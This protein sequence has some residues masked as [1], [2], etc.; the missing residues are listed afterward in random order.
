M[1]KYRTLKKGIDVRDDIFEEL[2]NL[3]L[4]QTPEQPKWKLESQG[5]DLT[6]Y[7]AHIGPSIACVKAELLLK[8][9]PEEV[10]NV[11][12]DWDRLREWD[13]YLK[14]LRIIE[15]YDSARD[16]TLQYLGYHSALPNHKVRYFLVFRCCGRDERLNSFFIGSKT[17]VH[18]VDTLPIDDALKERMKEGISCECLSSGWIVTPIYNQEDNKIYS[19]CTYV[20]QIDLKINPH[21]ETER[22]LKETG[23][24]SI[25]SFH[26]Y[27]I[28]GGM[29]GA[30]LIGLK[31][32]VLINRK[33][34]AKKQHSKLAMKTQKEA[35]STLTSISFKN[36]W[37]S[38]FK[39]NN[40]SFELLSKIV[41]PSSTSSSKS[42]SFSISSDSLSP[43]SSPPQ[44]SSLSKKT[45]KILDILN[46]NNTSEEDNLVNAYQSF[47]SLDSDSTEDQEKYIIAT[48]GFFIC[49]NSAS[50]VFQYLTSDFKSNNNNNSTNSTSPTFHVGKVV[51]DIHFRGAKEIEQVD[52]DISILYCNS[53]PWCVPISPNQEIED[54]PTKHQRANSNTANVDKKETLEAE[55][56]KEIMGMDCSLIRSKTSLPD[57][58]YWI[59]YK[60]IHHSSIPK[61]N[62]YKRLQVLPSI[63]I[64]HPI[65]ANSC[66]VSFCVQVKN[67]FPLCPNL[68]SEFKYRLYTYID[69]IAPIIGA[70]I[71]SSVNTLRDSLSFQENGEQPFN[72][73]N[74][75]DSLFEQLENESEEGWMK[76]VYKIA[77]AIRREQEEVEKLDNQLS[78]IMNPIHVSDFPSSNISIPSTSPTIPQ[79]TLDSSLATFKQD[80]SMLSAPPSISP[81]TL[82]PRTHSNTHSHSSRSYVSPRMYSART[83]MSSSPPSASFTSVNTI[84]LETSVHPKPIGF[85]QVSDKRVF[86]R[87]LPELRHNQFDPKLNVGLKRKR[88]SDTLT[89]SPIA[90]NEYSP[91]IDIPLPP[92]TTRDCTFIVEIEKS[93]GIYKS[94]KLIYPVNII[95]LETLPDHLLL[96]ILS[97]LDAKSLCQA[98]AT[99]SKLHEFAKSQTLWKRLYISTWGSNIKSNSFHFSCLFLENRGVEMMDMGE[100]MIPTN[101][102]EFKYRSM[103]KLNRNWKT[104]NTSKIVNLSG[105]SSSVK[106]THFIRF[107][108]PQKYHFL[109]TGS[110][111]KVAK[112]W[113]FGNSLSD[114]KNSIE[115][116]YSIT[117]SNYGVISLHSITQAHPHW[118]DFTDSESVKIIIGYRNGSLSIIG[119]PLL[120]L[121]SEKKEENVSINMNTVVSSN[122]SSAF[123]PIY[124]NQ[125]L[126]LSDGFE[127][128]FDSRG[129]DSDLVIG[130]EDTT[131]T[132]WDVLNNESIFT[133][134]SHER[135]IN[136]V[137]FSSS[138]LLTGSQDKTIK[139][140]DIYG[141]TNDSLCSFQGHTGGI[142]CL[143][144]INQNL[145]ISGSNDKSLKLWDIRSPNPARNYKGHVGPVRCLVI[146][147]QTVENVG[148]GGIR[149]VSGGNDNSVK[150]WTLDRNYS[151]NSSTSAPLYTLEKHKGPVIAVDLWKNLL[152]SGSSDVSVNLYDFC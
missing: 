79:L 27:S 16:N 104:G 35:I 58:T 116:L 144:L 69:E 134:N 148:Y 94:S 60:S 121:N 97:F 19:T 48:R 56:M 28:L 53:L 30:L 25:F 130:W 95:S 110:G 11:L 17:V 123:I 131:L 143:K 89:A 84:E 93:D 145:F 126:N 105:H 86:S 61:N 40:S 36:G 23:F 147:E 14:E 127:Y 29:Y 66:L 10:Y 59:V 107:D 140:W 22:T 73:K 106:I 49:E 72:S 124:S 152:C 102:W 76:A 98:S 111:D 34:E 114:T 13:I 1:K 125:F 50:L 82:S 108:S 91:S 75:A 64:V 8:A 67:P 77:A 65:S 33:S 83:I 119:I 132:I 31:N 96:Y 43:S 139:L 54:K 133:T 24:L 142:T 15:C 52:E 101:D 150:I 2:R 100:M 137:A 51:E 117:G 120:N 37:I 45:M 99:Y 9:H 146:D 92:V 4:G 136:A 21:V 88:N 68:G 44:D 38:H 42:S 90:S 57:G 138:T 39:S 6:T 47:H 55:E 41:H 109:V 46:N 151:S 70:R 7:S 18:D 12:K 63:Y 128:V 103:D 78:K 141:S 113:R 81:Y 74:F 20:H 87:S 80:I 129:G 115:P 26:S 32:Y 71:I 135:R 112:V 118:D 5:N 149:F 122:S 3:V 62:E 85:G